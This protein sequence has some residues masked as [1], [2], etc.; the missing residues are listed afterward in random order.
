M[1]APYLRSRPPFGM[2]WGALKRGAAEV[3]ENAAQLAVNGATWPWRDGK[4]A[5]QLFR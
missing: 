5:G 4:G 2:P 1:M 3:A